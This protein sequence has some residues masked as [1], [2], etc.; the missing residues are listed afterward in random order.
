MARPVRIP[1]SSA[2]RRSGRTLAST[3]CMNTFARIIGAV[4]AA[5]AA[6]CFT[7]G[8]FVVISMLSEVFHLR[9]PGRYTEQ[10]MEGVT[11]GF[12]FAFAGSLF[13]PRKSRGIA[14]LS[15]LPVGIGTYMWLHAG[16]TFDG[17]PGWHFSACVAGGLMAAVIQAWR[18]HEAHG[19]PT[20]SLNDGPAMRPGNSGVTGGPPSVS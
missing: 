12:A 1:T 3:L 17:F 19:Q 15:L 9:P 18:G 7:I 2:P 6:A 20:A 10:V 4:A 5:F 8:G 13:A 14:A 11:R 16:Y